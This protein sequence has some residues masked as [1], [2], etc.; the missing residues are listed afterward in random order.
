VSGGQI[1][2]NYLHT[3]YRFTGTIGMSPNSIY[4]KNIAL[5][6]ILN[7]EGK[8]NATIS[9]QGFKSMRIN[10]DAAFRNFQVLSTTERDNNLFYGQ[11]YATGD[12]NITGPV[13]NLKFTA[14]A[15]TEKNTR[16]FIP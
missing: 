15:R 4:F 12:L 11:A 7:N 10:L 13:N 14:A 6:D 3:T 16:V 8:L 5:T 9:H 2:V 1:M